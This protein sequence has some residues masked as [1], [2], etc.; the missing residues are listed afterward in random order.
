MLSRREFVNIAVKTGLASASAP[1]W[2]HETSKRAFGQLSGTYKA[3]VVV[4]LQGGNDG[5]NMLIPLESAKYNEYAAIR[6][7][8]AIPQSACLPLTAAGTDGA[9]GFHPALGNIAQLY[10]D[11]SALVVANVGPLKTPATKSQLTVSPNLIPEA[12]LSHPAGAAQW[13]SAST[14][15]YPSTGW[16]GRVADLVG[17]QSGS[18]PPVLSAGINSI[19]SV[20]HSVQGIVVSSSGALTALP[21]GIDAAVLAIA[22]D[23]AASR[24]SLVAQAAKLRLQATQQQ[25][26]ISQALNAGSPLKTRFPTTQFG[27]VM[28]SI[29]GVVNGRSVI[30]ASRQIFYCQQGAYDTHVQQV[31]VQNGYLRDLDAGIGALTGALHEMGL[32]NDVLICTHSDFNRTLL[33]NGSGGTDH[34]WGSHQLIVG[35]GIRGGRIIGHVPDPELGG[36]LDLNGY[37]TWIPTLSVTQ[38][39]AGIGAWMGLSN[40]QLATVFPDLGNFSQGPILLT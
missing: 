7:L 18:L 36:S 17:S 12:L 9:Y 20:G 16:G 3:I 21:S 24:N 40:S 32:Q 26:L 25:V 29:A 30:G 31:S 10:N 39:T 28:E 6:S 37:G 19:F 23:D 27:Q 1:L 22:N 35:G 34:A 15:E 14:M 2:L 13:E 38:M 8:I 5:N 11:G 33:G 4:S